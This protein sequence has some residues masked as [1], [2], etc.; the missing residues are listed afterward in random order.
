MGNC[1]ISTPGAG[2][3]GK[4]N[5]RDFGRFS[6]EDKRHGKKVSFSSR[7]LDECDDEV[8]TRTPKIASFIKK[9]LLSN[10]T[11]S[12]QISLHQ[13]T[14]DD[15]NILVDAAQVAHFEPGER[16]ILKYDMRCE[17]LYIVRRG[18]FRGLDNGKTN[19]IL[20]E[21]DII[22]ET[23]FFYDCCQN[24]TVVAE[25][26]DSSAYCLSRRDFTDIVEK[27]RELKN[28]KLLGGLTPSQKCMLEETVTFVNYVR[29]TIALIPMHTD[30]QL[31]TYSCFF[32]LKIHDIIRILRL[33]RLCHNYI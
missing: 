32:I 27:E 31:S 24:Q 14:S 17:Y 8:E 29:G 7:T 22:G 16:L 15:M 6:L 30:R 1:K 10:G 5:K 2:D 9:S 12:Q 20:R 33:Y 23:G 4:K 26:D 19:I 3:Q 18:I 25:G 13:I 21:G 28:V 11:F